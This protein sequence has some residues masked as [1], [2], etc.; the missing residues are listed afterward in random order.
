[1]ISYIG[2]KSRMAKWIGEYIPHNETYVEVFGGAFWV[3]VNGNIESKQI[4]YN[5]FNKYMAN[6][7]ECF[8]TPQK[9]GKHLKRYESQNP[10]LFKM[11]QNGLNNIEEKLFN[12]GDYE[13]GTQ[14]AYCA[15]QVFSGS[16]VMESKFIDLKG[17]Y[18]SKYDALQRRLAKSDV[19][20]KLKRITNVENLDYTDLILKYD[21]ENT[22]FYVDPPYWKTENYYS[23]HDFDVEDHKKLIE[24]LKQTKGKWALSYYYFDLLEELLP[25]NE[26][27]WVEKE[28]T[29][30]AGAQKGKKQ[31]KG[32][33]LLI[34]NY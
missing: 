12:L 9:F 20:D 33:E 31:N 29:K 7:F 32:V 13:I 5:D 19:Q 11:F 4:V 27:T 24:I 21:G 25:K 26:F 18:S 6:L 8:R 28:F 17:K 23:N 10:Q 16:K 14:Y 22:F 34:M 30:A 1:M 15:T 2:G 3:Y